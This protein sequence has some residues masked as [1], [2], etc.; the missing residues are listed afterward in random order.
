MLVQSLL[1]ILFSVISVSALGI[2]CR[3]SGLCPVSGGSLDGVIGLVEKIDGVKSFKPGEQIA[4]DA[5]L[6]AFT[7]STGDDISQGTA[8]EKLKDLK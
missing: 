3:G 6:C 2:N 1:P 8:L 4:C 7:Q 5:N